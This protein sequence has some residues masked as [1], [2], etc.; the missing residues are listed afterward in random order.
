MKELNR[1]S[2][3]NESI[4]ELLDDCFKSEKQETILDE[5]I[6]T[7]R[8]ADIEKVIEILIA[9][10]QRDSLIIKKLQHDKD[11]TVGLWA[12]DRPDL[13]IDEKKIMFQIS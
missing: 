12:T 6:R 9:E 5:I 8:Y 11:T 13:V 4:Y 7:F 3:F 1:Q 10:R 2:K